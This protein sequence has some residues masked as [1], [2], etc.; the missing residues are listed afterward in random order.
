VQ[1]SGTVKVHIRSTSKPKANLSAVLVDIPG[2]DEHEQR[3]RERST[4][5]WIDPE[6]RTDEAAQRGGEPAD[7]AGRLRYDVIHDAAEGHDRRDG[8]PARRGARVQRQR[9]SIR[10]RLTMLNADLANSWVEIPVGRRHVPAAF[11]DTALTINAALTLAAAT[12]SNGWYTG[13]VASRGR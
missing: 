5:G 11:G 2:T 12:G 8:P 4:R 10:R 1:I 13:D 7:H 9:G 3:H 6:N